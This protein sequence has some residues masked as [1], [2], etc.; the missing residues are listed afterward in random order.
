[1]KH[2]I[3]L[4]FW[5]IMIALFSIAT[6]T[7]CEFVAGFPDSNRSGV[8]GSVITVDDE[9]ADL[10]YYNSLNYTETDGTLPSGV[11][12]NKYNISNMVKVKVTYYGRDFLD[13]SL[14]GKVSTTEN[15]DTYIYYHWYPVR[16]GKVVIPLIDNPF[17]LR[18]RGKGF[19]SWIS[20]EE[21]VKVYLDKDTYERYAIVTPVS[22]GNGYTNLNVSFYAHWIDAKEG[23]SSEGWSTV[24][25]RFDTYDLHLVNTTHEVCTRPASVNE[26]VMDGYYLMDH[27]DRYNYYSGYYVSGGRIRTAN[28]RYCNTNGGCDYWIMIDDG[29]LYDDGTTYYRRNDAGNN[30]T[31]VT[32]AYI[33]EHADDVCHDEDTF[34]SSS[35]VAGFYTPAGNIARNASIEGLY[36][37]EGNIQSGTCNT[38]G[39]C[40][41]LYKYLDKYD[42]NGNINYFQS[43]TRYYY[44]ATR[45]TNIVHL[46]T[47]NLTSNWGTSNTYNKPFTFTGILENGTQ[48]SNRW[49]P[50]ANITLVNDTRIEHMT[51]S[52][53]TSYSSADM[54]NSRLLIAS[55]HNL[56]IGRG[57]EKY[58]DYY[59]EY[60]N[61]NG[62]VGGN[63]STGSS[64]NNTRYKLII[65]SG[66]FNNT[67]VTEPTNRYDYDSLYI[68]ADAVYGNDLDRVRNNNDN[69][70]VY[71]EATASWAG[72]IYSSN[73]IAV[74]QTVKSGKFGTSKADMYTGIYVGGVLDGTY[75]AARAAKIEGGWIYNLIGG[76]LTSNSRRGVNDTYI[77][78]TGGSVDL[79]VGGAGRSSTYGNRIISV[80]GGSVNYSILGGS[81]G[82][83]SNTTDGDGTLYGSSFIY[84]GGD[85]VIGDNTLASNADMYG[86]KP[87]NV[88]GNGNGKSGYLG[89]GSN[90]NS[91]IV[92]N[93]NC[94]IRD[95]VYGGG[96]YGMTG[97]S[98]GNS[99]A[100]S[101][102]TV[103]NGRINGDIYGGGNQNK[104]D[105]SST[106]TNVIINMSGGIVSGSIYGG[107]N[108]SGVV[109]GNTNVNVTG[110]TVT[111][112]VYGGGKG[113]NT[114]VKRNAN[115]T[116]G[117]VNTN[118]PTINS[119]YGGSAFGTVNNYP[120]SS[121]VSSYNTHVVVNAGTITN[122][123]GGGQGDSDNTPYVC[124][125]VEVD[126]NGG[127]LTNV[128]GGNDLKGTPNG[129]V[130]VNINGGTVTSAYAGGNQTVVTAPTMN[131]H[132]GTITSAFGGGN[133]AA[134]TTSHVTVDGGTTTNVFGGSNASG[135]VT[136]SNVV[137]HNG[138]VTNVFG[139][140]NVGGTT[141]TTN[142]TVDGGNVSTVYGGGE[143]T[144]VTNKTNVTISSAVGNV[145]G[146]SDSNGTVKETN[147]NMKVGSSADNVYGGNNLGGT[148]TTSHVDINGG[149]I[150][151]TY[152]GGLQATTGD[153]NVN[154]N[155]GMSTNI[156]GGGN[157]AGATSTHVNLAK[158]YSS[159]VFGGSNNSGNIPNSYINNSNS[160][161]TNS[162]ISAT[163]TKSVS[164]INQTNNQDK[165]SSETLNVS[166][167]NNTGVQLTT[168]DA[169]IFVSDSVFD[170][171]WSGT[172]VEVNG[173]VVHANQ[174][175]QWYG[176]NPLNSGSSHSFNFNIHSS[177]EYDDYK[178]YGYMIIGKDASGNQYQVVKF[179]DDDLY[180]DKLF[181]GN[182]QG[183]V[184]TN[185]HVNL[186]S[187]V[188]GSI[189]GGGE[190]ATTTTPDV[191]LDGVTVND[192]VYGGGD[193]APIS[194]NTNVEIKNNCN[195][196]GN[197][198]GGGNNGK[199][200]GNAVV[201]VNHSTVAKSIYGGGNKAD[202]DGI[203]TVTVSNSSI[204]SENVFGGGNEG[205]VLDDTEVIVNNSTV[206][207]SVYGGGNKANVEGKT[208]VSI[209]SGA[210]IS[211]N[212]FGG[213]NE[214]K[215]LDD[216]KVIVNN[217]TVT[218]SVYGGGNKA[219]VEG[220]TDVSILNG[221]LISENVF[222]GGNEGKALD[223]TKV[224]VD[225][226]QV[227]KTVYGGGNKADV[228]GN[229][230]VNIRNDALI[231]ENVFG[232]GNEA[233]VIG[234]TSLD[235]DVSSVSG[236]VFGGGNNG[237]VYG[238]T[239]TLIHNTSVGE[240]AYAGGNGATA[241][242]YGNNT[243]DVDGTTS[244]THHLFGGGNAAQTG[245][246]DDVVVSGNTVC[247]ANQSYSKVNIAG[248][249]IGGNVY[250][251]ANTSVVY[252]ETFV[253]IGKDMIE[254]NL[255]KGNIHISG[256]V[257]GGGEA[258]AS[259][260]EDY[261]FNFIS[262]TRGI[263]INI[264]ANGHNT[265][266]IDGSI[267]GSGNA[268]SSGGYSYVNIHNYGT[269][270]D[271]KENISIQRSDIVTLDNSS[272][273]LKGAQDRTNKYKS[274]LF[275]FSRIGHLK[276]KNGSSV[277]LEKGAN[278][279]EKFSSMV[280]SNGEEVLE[281]VTI[282]KNSKT[283]SQNV[284]N[285]VY[286]MEGKNLNIS[287]D[288]SLATYGDVNGMAFYGMFKR[289]RNGHVATGR[290]SPNYDYGSS[291]SGSEQ[292]YFNSGSYAVGKHKSS[293]DYY[294]DGFYSNY[295]SEDG[296]TI[297]VDY[298]EP[299]PSDAP[300]YRWI[301]GESVEVLE[302]NL[303]ASKYST[304]GTY[305]LQL[306]DYYHPN[307]E[308]NVLG[309]N[310]DNLSSNINLLDDDDIPRVA[311]SEDA[312]NSDFGLAMKSGNVGWI[313]RGE[314]SFLTTGQ[315]MKGTTLYRAENTNAIPSFVF[316]LYHSKNITKSQNMG[317]IVISLM[318]ATP[319]NDLSNKMQRINIEVSLNTALY[320]GDNYEGSIA[321]GYQYELFANTN[322]NVT[323]RSAFS[324]Y[325]SLYSTTP[326]L[327]KSGSYRSLVSSYALP[328]NTKITMIDFAAGEHPS[329]YYYV[330]DQAKYQ[331][332]VLA[333]Q[334]D[335][336][337]SYR[338]SDFIKM[339]SNSSNN[340]YNDALANQVYYNSSNHNSEEEFIFII[341]LKDTA[342]N[343]DVLHQSMLLELR[344][345]N[346][347]PIIPVLDISQQKM[348]YNLYSNRDAVINATASL[349]NNSL[350]VGQDV[351]LTVITDF[352]QQRIGNTTVIDTNFYD[353][354]L[355][356]KLSLY[357]SNG[358]LV[359]G[360]SMLGTAFVYQGVRYYPRQDG[361]VRFNIAESIA[362]VSS[363]IK[364]DATN[365]SLSTGNYK[366]VID[367]FGSSDGIYYGLTSSK[368][369]E[370]NIRIINDLFG[371][372]VDIN[373][374]DVL[375]DKDT[376][377]G[378]DKN[379]YI[380]F[381]L[382]YS[383]GL[384]S[385]NIR[386]SMWRR[387]YTDVYHYDFEM[388]DFQD[389]VK[390]ELVT[391]VQNK[392]Y[393]IKD[394]PTSRFQYIVSLKDHLKTGTYQIRFNLYDGDNYVGHVNKYII[395][396]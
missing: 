252:G 187:G 7:Y 211:E 3:N 287:D 293:H 151:N 4:V 395:I 136:T 396:E 368:S 390:D 158:G 256:T 69:L 358:E 100:E 76:P 351:D 49:T 182:N 387:T 172:N 206:T 180:V 241:T 340:T 171:N 266:L 128:F 313:T 197:V 51:I 78:M 315:D 385:P 272:I 130:T 333:L 392:V 276:L 95:S 260:S 2:K 102:I 199:V 104:V 369:I 81:N 286:M 43:G 253:N 34:S 347:N 148:T 165:V 225:D 362:N 284:D 203:T 70:E 372:K 127:T 40:N 54:N 64:S 71:Y 366:L 123:F 321:P 223:D 1:M 306:L 79:I 185:S 371:L 186:T 168:W 248:A 383:S 134:V 289:D 261:D 342:L 96:N 193:Q 196:L 267:F 251:G 39:G 176:T 97:V 160:S 376:G 16:D 244:I 133:N 84:V 152:G 352:E 161:I 264:D 317:S 219:D 175:N 124:G 327:Y 125:N 157:K 382:Q 143:K 38:N 233:N 356:I 304:L 110:G 336:E 67:S 250:G 27:V 19:N 92:I 299:S 93:E 355:G 249:T 325:F 82:N 213:G 346:D 12:Q 370:K 33:L 155:Y 99:T 6:V 91:Y 262:V 226:S 142:V 167:T 270:S 107:A 74:W 189:Y 169:Y 232:G 162:N 159:L 57:L 75:N 311:D 26:V 339:G 277:Y 202:V 393:L 222:G 21:G 210:L 257:F 194:T 231:S 217:S 103:L 388:V 375:I 294:K 89:I 212:V 101:K 73:E 288:E 65:E 269:I 149:V 44:L 259:G 141:G 140:N 5:L 278:L 235:L 144:D 94:T 9:K 283:V 98:S 122:T 258:N 118:G 312:A 8:D 309:V 350:Y 112:N 234:N 359:N 116:I 120:A 237:I 334:S 138:T 322:V 68:Q 23:N 85:A 297:V 374:N 15:Y 331:A 18:P 119:V 117:T 216:T 13:S 227:T 113:S 207:K 53:G 200:N 328:V 316:Y 150:E 354:K 20:N 378:V 337:V 246:A 90:D 146:G 41:N 314:T 373:Q 271:P 224:I 47:S 42:D 77:Y 184:T 254:K 310:F 302:V 247:H 147:I 263:N 243:I 381:Q 344:D 275:T 190:K 48:S 220:K 63:T 348:F 236:S 201:S 87:G 240:S 58:S 318:I 384:T 129:T 274:E 338:L 11:D 179:G 380:D 108:T 188:Y 154:L 360:A 298:I 386:V 329:Y 332:S 323:S 228:S 290:Y 215:A 72:N 367:T 291:I 10:Y 192:V 183:G 391:T 341:D 324:T 106:A 320:D 343:Q 55:Y 214:G 353:K 22:D 229:T 335:R 230:V 25:G 50:G 61:F 307:T 326:N 153:T 109:T 131:I 389:Y 126:V 280:D 135:N 145:F 296:S 52:S 156:Y 170:S 80:T 394:N 377:M 301:I 83:I 209:L 363:K 46:N 28:Y 62:L 111:G 36:D 292:Y 56:K 308:V 164:T 114:Y 139:G 319:L 285:R 32:D 279:L 265:F 177:V 132:G 30:F 115:V 166:I 88:F 330:I 191:K 17:A 364:I 345:T 295:P 349:S 305:E 273:A 137:I 60:V 14:V 242:V 361:T 181:G 268:S 195:I 198:F 178:I 218:K 29:S 300:Y 163:I 357:D 174:V 281:V 204:V 105:D 59:G 35:I 238:N 86:V 239:D 245:C 365:S 208:D 24:F 37:D 121:S 205:K 221:A 66:Y 282:S 173:S 45:D 379:D 303:T 255:T 31:T